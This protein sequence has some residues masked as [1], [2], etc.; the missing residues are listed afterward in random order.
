VVSAESL[1]YELVEVGDVKVLGMG[2]PLPKDC[3][4]CQVEQTKDRQDSSSHIASEVARNASPSPPLRPILEDA[5]LLEE[6]SGFI[7]PARIIVKTEITWWWCYG[8]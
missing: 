2:I 3:R 5:S 4:N 7:R 8:Q 1:R 6:P